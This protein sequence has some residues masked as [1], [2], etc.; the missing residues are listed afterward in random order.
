MTD[1]NEPIAIQI[2]YFQV[3][4]VKDEGAVLEMYLEGKEEPTLVN[5]P[6]NGNEFSRALYTELDMCNLLHV[7]KR[8]VLKSPLI[9]Q[10]YKVNEI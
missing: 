2:G 7:G 3:K 5:V 6:K 8:F 10:D 9:T 4:D 1:K